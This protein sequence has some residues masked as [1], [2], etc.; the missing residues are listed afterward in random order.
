MHSL[1]L[2]AWKS[3]TLLSDIFWVSNLSFA[4]A[5]TWDLVVAESTT[6]AKTEQTIK[7]NISKIKSK[8][9]VFKNWVSYSEL[10][11]KALAFHCIQRCF[12]NFK[13]L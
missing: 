1:Q 3:G 6:T 10:T 13:K 4:L 5:L 12:M 8:N 9:I 11:V 2:K 7:K